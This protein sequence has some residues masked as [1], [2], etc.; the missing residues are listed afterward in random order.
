MNNMQEQPNGKTQA[1]DEL[2]W[3]APEFPEHPKPLVWYVIYGLATGTLV[4]YG[5]SVDSWTTAVAFLFFGIMGIYAA[6]RKPKS[7]LVRVNGQGIEVDGNRYPYESIRRFW[8]LYHP[9]HIKSIYFET[10]AYFNGLVKVEL[11]QQDPR[12][13]REL[14][15]RYLEENLDGEEPMVDVI[16]RRLRF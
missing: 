5:V 4:M 2:S 14:L 12:P 6:S 1:Q 7:V 10:S 8:V 3:H 16:A 11:A 9:P 13:V 15:A